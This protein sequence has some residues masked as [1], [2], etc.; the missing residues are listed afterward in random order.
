ML[1]FILIIFGLCVVI[2]LVVI[3]SKRAITCPH[4]K[5]VNY[6]SKNDRRFVCPACKQPVD[7]DILEG[8][9]VI[10]LALQ[11]EDATRIF[12]MVDECNKGRR[13]TLPKIKEKDVVLF[14]LNRITAEDLETLRKHEPK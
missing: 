12:Q 11:R 8:K 5:N 3:V 1:K 14:A 4:C 6:I 10:R 9:N 7:L 13:P 2:Y